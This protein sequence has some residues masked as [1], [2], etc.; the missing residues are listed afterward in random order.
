MRSLIYHAVVYFLAPGIMLIML[1]AGVVLALRVPQRFR[2]PAVAGLCA[3]LVGFVIY[4]VSSSKGF[5]AP[6]DTVTTLPGFHWLPT[7]LG[8]LLGFGILRLLEFLALNSGLFGLFILILILSS[9]VAVYSYFFPSPLRDFTILFALSAAVGMLLH[10]MLFP[11]RIRGI[12]K[13]TIQ[14][15]G[16]LM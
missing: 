5:Q 11:N 10:I 13:G 6:T 16:P 9:S 2:V 4:V 3:G 14:E 7:T 15:D 12:M 1:A 8:L